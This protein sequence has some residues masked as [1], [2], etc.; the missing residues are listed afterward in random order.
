MPVRYGLTPGEFAQM[1]NTERHIGCQLT[2]IPMEGWKR[3]QL[4]PALG[5][6]FMMPSPAI[7]RFDNALL[8]AGNCIFEGVNLSEGR[9]TADPFAL[10]GAPFLDAE[11][12][13]ARMRAL[14]LP[15]VLFT[16]ATFKPTASKH[17]GVMCGGVHFHLVDAQAYRPLETAVRLLDTV[18]SM[19]PEQLEM[20][21]FEESGK[22][23]LDLLTGSSALR[24]GEDIEQ[25]LQTWAQE[26]QAF[27]ARKK[28][29][30]L[31]ESDK[32]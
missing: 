4:F 26:S 1:A 3:E 2:V 13:C 20:I 10:I 24:E 25:L 15:G 17:R 30:E 16:P 14:H 18:R 28:K 31:Y 19:A 23:T 11:A 21:Q 7:P 22:Y 9:G 12:L 29:Y 32:K 8:Y 6:P 5:Y 27:T